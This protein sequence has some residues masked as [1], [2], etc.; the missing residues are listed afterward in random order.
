MSAFSANEQT[1][2]T[3]L[4]NVRSN[5]RKNIV[6]TIGA[7]GREEKYNYTPNMKIIRH[8]CLIA[9]T[10]FC[11][12]QPLSAQRQRNY[13]YVFD[14][15]RSMLNLKLWEPAKKWLK[16]DIERQSDE[17]SITI[18]PFRDNPLDVWKFQKAR[19][20]WSELEKKLE[21][22]V[23]Q[24][25]GYTGICRAWDRGLEELNP[26]KDN[27]Y[28]LMTDGREEC[29]KLS[30]LQNRLK[31][32]CN[33]KES[34]YGFFVTLSDEAELVLKD[35]N[36]D[37]DRFFTIDGSKH[38]P[39]IG[40]FAPSEFTVNL[41]EIK[42]KD[43]LF[44]TYGEFP[45]SVVC[46]D[47]NFSVS[48]A[49][50]HIAGGKARFSVK[51]VKDKNEL[52]NELPELYTF[53]CQIQ[54]KDKD[55]LFMPNDTVTVRVSNKPVRNLTIVSEEQAGEAEWYDS[56]LFFDKKEQDT[57]NIQLQNSWNELAKKYKSAIR[58]NV[59][60]DKLKPE[61][62]KLLLN[63]KEVP[64][65]SFELTSESEND[66]LSVIFAD[67]TPDDTYYFNIKATKSACHNLETI[68]DEEITTAAYENTLRLEYD[69]CWNPLKT[70]IFWF[71]L[72]LA[73]L[74]ILWFFL[75]RPMMISRFKIGSIMVTDPY[76]SNIRIHRARRLIFTSKQKKD[77]IVWRI[78]LG[79]TIYSIN[80]VWTD[81]LEVIP[82]LKKGVK[83]ITKGK[84][85][86]DPYAANLQSG[87]D[88]TITHNDTNQQIKITVN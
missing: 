31:H 43:L 39:P 29:D 2:S 85:T 65:T 80:P 26:D 37:C 7:G 45:V 46:N 30:N 62:Y 12:I 52:I 35:L 8:I 70:F 68:N 25:G 78:L 42:D 71:L 22:I 58:F 87:N 84:Y 21:D 83:V 36:I 55:E 49:D 56:C 61:Q 67:D 64:S 82:G 14:C 63:G 69:V 6:S 50:N 40:I 86:I 24:P 41:R 51:P 5:L 48:I 53:Q 19:L 23:N 16:E 75:L 72:I 17:A 59:A 47:P 20:E 32:W 73:A 4:V 74:T 13:I 79:K 88:Y 57:I 3:P 38:I 81:D 11:T 76:F 34:D 18:I 27:Y 77:N 15:T 28:Y 1:G 9:I 33:N 10:L 54:P 60:C 66:I 44:S